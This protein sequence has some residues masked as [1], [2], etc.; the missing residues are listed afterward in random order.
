MCTLHIK[1]AS[2]PPPH[3]LGTNN[4]QDIGQGLQC[5]SSAC[6]VHRGLT[7]ARFGRGILLVSWPHHQHNDK[8]SLR[9]PHRI[10]VAEP[11][12]PT[13]PTV[14]G[15]HCGGPVFA[16]GNLGLAGI[17][18]LR[19]VWRPLSRSLTLARMVR[20]M[21]GVPTAKKVP[22]ASVHVYTVP[23]PGHTHATS[24]DHLTGALCVSSP[25][26]RGST[27]TST[28]RSVRAS[29]PSPS[30][31]ENVLWCLVSGDGVGDG[32]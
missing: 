23:R 27:G 7:L 26:A 19:R 20:G 13:K 11:D 29:W 4:L 16:G 22:Y 24:S 17:L 3:A 32:E 1:A 21:L 31:S 2:P 30:A 28:H 6:F 15:H 9:L 18:I 8:S 10:K 25:A 14:D 12:R 5:A